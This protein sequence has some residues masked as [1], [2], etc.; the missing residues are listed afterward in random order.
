MNAETSTS[1]TQPYVHRNSDATSPSERPPATT[2][3]RRR[4][5][6]A[7]EPDRDQPGPDRARATRTSAPASASVRDRPSGSPVAHEDDRERGADGERRPDEVGTERD[8]RGEPAGELVGG[9][10]RRRGEG[11]QAG[12]GDQ[13]RPRRRR[14]PAGR[15]RRGAAG[16]LTSGES[17]PSSSERVAESADARRPSRGRSGLGGEPLRIDQDRPSSPA[18]RRPVEA[19]HPLDVDDVGHERPGAGRVRGDEIEL[20]RA[21]P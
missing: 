11:D 9:D 16:R 7:D 4:P 13:P 15:P 3:P 1:P 10:G 5:G 18:R 12:D 6:P 21:W 17:T 19:A 20:E 8:R 14:R 2:W